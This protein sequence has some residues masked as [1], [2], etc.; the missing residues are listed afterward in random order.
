MKSKY[1]ALVL[2]LVV[3]AGLNPAEAL[4][5]SAP[6][7]RA[8]ASPSPTP[9]QK[10]GDRPAPNPAAA[11]AVTQPAVPTM[12]TPHHAP[13]QLDFGQVLDGKSATRTLSLTT[14]APGYVTVNI[15]P[16]PFR[17]SEFREMAQT[18][19]PSKINNGQ[20]PVTG[21]VRSRI[22][23]QEGQ[24]GPFQ[25]SMAPNTEMQIDVVFT[26][27]AQDGG[28]TFKTATMN[29]SGPG[30][31]GNWVLPV[32]LHGSL[33]PISLTP[34]P[35]QPSYKPSNP[36][37]QSGK[38]GNSPG[39]A[40]PGSAGANRPAMQKGFSGKPVLL[41][42]KHR[43]ELSPKGMN[44]KVLAQL[45]QQNQAAAAERT[46]IL[47]SNRGGTGQTTKSIGAGGATNVGLANSSTS[48]VGT[49]NKTMQTSPGPVENVL[50]CAKT[51]DALIFS[52]NGQKKGVVFTTDPDSNLFTLIGCNFG[53]AQGSMHLYGGFAHGNIPFEIQF[54][55]DKNIVARVQPDLAGELDRDGVTLVVV[56]SNGHQTA[57]QGLK[58]YAARQTYALSDIPNAASKIIFGDPD[59]SNCQHAKNFTFMS[60]GVMSDAVNGLAVVVD[61]WGVQGDKGTD[62]LTL[63]GLK[64]G[65]EVSDVSLWISPEATDK[66]GWS[67]TSFAENISVGYVFDWKNACATYGLRISVAG[68]RGLNSVWK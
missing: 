52:I 47:G 61:R 12:N 24:N 6:G 51:P 56:S 35:P 39:L 23:Y 18:Q 4:Q 49:G 15:P 17:V 34:G 10:S 11:M 13:D 54:W 7:A 63:S 14:N 25:W 68:P 1:F 32:P 22:K 44:L 8:I 59:I 5:A 36:I 37:L 46:R 40:S 9:P 21:G 31:H 2:L 62:Q 41:M 16:G 38:S 66:Q 55:N 58:F 30:P 29:V 42:S 43:A 67:L 45:Q 65:F 3:G 64:P 48:G 19:N 33:S 20:M 28:G 60:C 50:V 27:K 26:P 57:F 53:D